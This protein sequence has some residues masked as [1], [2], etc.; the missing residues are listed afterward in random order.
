MTL[1]QHYDNM[2][3]NE[4]TEAMLLIQKCLKHLEVRKLMMIIWRMP[5]YGSG[6][7]H[8]ELSYQHYALLKVLQNIVA[9]AALNK[10]EKNRDGRISSANYLKPIWQLRTVYAGLAHQMSLLDSLTIHPFELM[11]SIDNLDFGCI[12]WPLLNLLYRVDELHL[13]GSLV[14]KWTWPLTLNTM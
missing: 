8:L 1:G 5:S 2:D 6:L 4:T 13:N 7:L 12:W 11:P 10:V 9:C 3:Y 14:Q